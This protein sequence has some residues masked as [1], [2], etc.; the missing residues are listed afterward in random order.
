MHSDTMTTTTLFH[1]PGDMLANIPGLLGFYPEKSIICVGFRRNSGHR[2]KLGPV[3]RTD[4]DCIDGVADIFERSDRLSLELLFL[5]IVDD[6]LY[7]E[8]TQH[9]ADKT[10]IHAHP[11]LERISTLATRFKAPVVGMWITPGLY[12]NET[13]LRVAGMPQSELDDNVSAK[14]SWNS[15]K[16]P[17]IAQA[18]ATKDLL[19]KG[20]L[21]EAHRSDLEKIFSPLSVFE[22]VVEAHYLQRHIVDNAT[23]AMEQAEQKTAESAATFAAILD[24][25]WEILA[26]ARAALDADHPIASNQELLV[27]GAAFFAAQPLRDISFVAA[28]A[29][30]DEVVAPGTQ[31]AYRELALAVARVF[32][33]ELRANALCAY[34]LAAAD[35]GLLVRSVPALRCAL[36]TVPGHGLAK[37]LECGFHSGLNKPLLTAC[38]EG[39]KEVRSYYT[40]PTQET[41]A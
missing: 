28:E 24:E 40:T 6:A 14:P 3:F 25:L 29:G 39:G 36:N 15:G 20:I 12:S 4:I 22:D 2:Y 41:A 37:L 32:D 18:A 35:S 1:S 19:E 13:Y 27:Q 9:N 38:I 8:F 34:A 21:P 23:R 17:Q 7:R 5:F 33:G 11:H 16:I 10:S 30:I 26:T 31:E